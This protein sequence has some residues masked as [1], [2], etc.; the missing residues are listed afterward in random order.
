MND[1]YTIR[2]AKAEDIGLL[3]A[4]ER[5]AAVRFAPYGL[6]QVM[7]TVVTDTAQFQA[8]YD[9]GQLWV[10]ANAKDLPVGFA[11]AGIVGGCAHL[12]ELDVLPAHGRQGLGSALVQAVHQWASQY[13]FPAV[14]LT[15]LAHIPWNRPFY[16]HLGYHIVL[17]D[18]LS[19]ALRALL[20]DEAA[21]GLPSKG[22]VV[23]SCT[24]PTLRP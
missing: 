6:A 17:P 11:L 3:P 22:R 1:T 4:I 13:G 19:D 7:A 12:D 8:A 18:A 10:A 9:T 16:E 14:T 20:L 23:M 15:T 24:L 21:H 5:E 2:L